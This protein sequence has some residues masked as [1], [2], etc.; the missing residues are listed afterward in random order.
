M[1]DICSQLSQSSPSEVS[2]GASDLY[3]VLPPRRLGGNGGSGSG[4][5]YQQSPWM[6]NILEPYDPHMENLYG[7]IRKE[8]FAAT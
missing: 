3:A 4:D 2:P 6:D 5:R 7:R 8:K 1:R